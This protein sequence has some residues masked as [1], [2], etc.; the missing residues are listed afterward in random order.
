[1]ILG[2]KGR[3][4]L[5]GGSGGDFFVFK[6]AYG[7]DRIK[8]FQDD[9]DTIRLDDALWNGSGLTKQQVID[10]YAS[11]VGG[12]LVFDFAAKG[13]LTVVGFTDLTEIKDDMVFI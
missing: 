8:D 6:N 1:M 13:K 2:G 10:T 3:D 7:K 4:N 5:T 12:N 11:V 9:L